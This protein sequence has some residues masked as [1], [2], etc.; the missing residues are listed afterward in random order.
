MLRMQS[1]YM[2]LVVV[3]KGIL[4]NHR[5]VTAFLLVSGHV[6]VMVDK[7]ERVT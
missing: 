1:A 4:L 5:P 3:V 6:Y 7:P 2:M